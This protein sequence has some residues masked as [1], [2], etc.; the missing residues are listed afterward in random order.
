[1]F[2]LTISFCIVGLIYIAGNAMNSVELKTYAHDELYQVIMS[3]ILVVLFLAFLSFLDTGLAPGLSQATGG[4]SSLMVS[5]INVTDVAVTDMKGYLKGFE[6]LVTAV[7]REGSRSAYCSFLGLGM[8]VVSCSAL[9][10]MRGSL[11]MGLN[12]IS[13]ALADLYAQ[14]WILQIANTTLVSVF[15]PLG[16]LLRT[17]KFSRQAGGALL[18]IFFGFYIVFPTTIIF[19]YQLISSM[20]SVTYSYTIGSTT[21]L[22]TLVSPYQNIAIGV[23]TCNPFNP[24]YGPI[25][26][27]AA[28]VFQN[29]SFYEPV[30]FQVIIRCVFLTAL[31]LLITLSSIRAISSFLGSEIEV[32]GLVRIA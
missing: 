3:G 19:G 10:S 28:K 30:V 25:N 14:K 27:F 2:A 13:F 6:G 26:N 23:P 18:A 7:G 4:T 5:A 9:N 8:T 16:I 15:L 20:S 17:L 31:N 29:P 1:M 12:A 32:S 24:E 11:T 21:M 22:Y